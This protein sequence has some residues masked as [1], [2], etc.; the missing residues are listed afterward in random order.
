MTGT[1][2]ARIV[3]VSPL[4]AKRNSGSSSEIS[5][6]GI[7]AWN[8]EEKLIFL[9]KKYSAESVT[10]FTRQLNLRAS[11]GGQMIYEHKRILSVFC[12]VLLTNAWT[13]KL[14]LACSLRLP[15]I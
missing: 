11:V 7:S 6:T 3:F 4:H 8:L 10:S 12:H 15:L 14:S 9:K 2:F 13:Y 5:S 1:G